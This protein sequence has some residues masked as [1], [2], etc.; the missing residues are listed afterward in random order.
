M[1]APGSSYSSDTAIGALQEVL[2]AKINAYYGVFRHPVR[3]VVY[4]ASA[5]AYN[6]PWYGIHYQNFSHVAKA[7]ARMVKGQSRFEKIYLFKTF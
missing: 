6:T 2:Q 1:S 3:L 4:Y 7:A 5:V